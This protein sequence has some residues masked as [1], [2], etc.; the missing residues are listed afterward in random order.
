METEKLEFYFSLNFNE[1]KE[2]LKKDKKLC[3]ELLSNSRIKEKIIN[4][5]NKYEFIWL[6]QDPETDFLPL[7]L[8][9]SGVDILRRSSGWTD[10]INGILTSCNPCVYKLFEDKSFV[11]L[12]IENLEKLKSSLYSLPANAIVK[13]LEYVKKNNLNSKIMLD[14]MS[15]VGARYQE[16]VV[17][18]FK[19][20][21][22]I[23]ERILLSVEDEAAQYLINQD[24][25]I[26]TL[27]NLSFDGLLALLSKNIRIPDYFLQD[28]EFQKKIVT[29]FDPKDYRFLIQKLGM[30]NDI[31][32]LEKL[33]K[34]FY[35]NEIK[36]YN[37]DTK[38]LL[39]YHQIYLEIRKLILNENVT[40]QNIEMIIKESFNNFGQGDLT[41]SFIEKIFANSSST[42]KL[43][44]YFQKR[45]NYHLTNMII[46]YHFEDVYYNFLL[47]VKQL[48]QFQQTEGRTLNDQDTE[49]YRRLLT[50]D[51]LP[52]LQKISLFEELKKVNIIEKYYDDFR[53]SKD[54][55]FS[56][57]KEQML[58]F[59]NI[60]QYKSLEL[61]R[62][63][64]VD[65]YV[66]AGQ[67]FYAFVKSLNESKKTVLTKAKIH[68]YTDGSSYSL[69][70]S[71]KL[72]TFYNPRENY[73]LLFGDF[74]INQVVHMYSSDS[75]SKYIRDGKNN[76]GTNRVFELYTPSDF[77]KSSANYNEIIYSQRNERKSDAL[78]L[79]LDVPRVLSI[80]CYDEISEND[81][82]SAK[83]LGIGITLIKTKSYHVRKK[84]EQ[85]SVADTIGFDWNKRNDF[86]YITSVYEDAMQGRK[87]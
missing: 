19:F 39:R 45:S 64:G 70:G 20:P 43:K 30:N 40:R 5:T 31:S 65:I 61:S 71:D 3:R 38:M 57:I 72:S 42:E 59:N 51:D 87:M 16:D 9:A 37:P 48:Y 76:L 68:Y 74:S 82:R 47:D 22:D 79:Q 85:L 27:N 49:L 10:K 26:T 73:N 1:L 8:N 32:Y 50:L 78:N 55:A 83:N 33:R 2:L 13:M 44:T 62:K 53:K 17:K 14:I 29:I 63:Y 81:I 21:F 7:L 4:P 34:E 12:V 46:D 24:L 11:K 18:S 80:Y 41:Y 15:G 84:D 66:L 54:K 86:N 28:K 25:R 67:P 60:G 52:Y 35:E 23:L 58:N 36:S 75:F 56:L 77:V 69:D 6:A